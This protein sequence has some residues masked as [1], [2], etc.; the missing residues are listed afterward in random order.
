MA[1]FAMPSHKES[2]VRHPASLKHLR[3]ILIVA[4]L[5]SFLCACACIL[6]AAL[7]GGGEK[8][9]LGGVGFG[10]LFFLAFTLDHVTRT[11]EYSEDGARM[12]G[13]H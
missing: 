11:S 1:A 12:A 13:P 4:M 7:F 9:A 8:A 5:A 2:I 3:S 10:T 6:A